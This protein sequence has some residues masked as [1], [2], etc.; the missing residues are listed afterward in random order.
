[1]KSSKK[2]IGNYRDDEII[3]EDNGLF[4][5]GDWEARNTSFRFPETA[6]T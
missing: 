3:E 6:V 1:M 4:V 2:I 5:L